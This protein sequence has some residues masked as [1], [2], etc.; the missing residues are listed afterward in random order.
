MGPLIFDKDTQI[1]VKKKDLII[2]E[3]SSIYIYVEIYRFKM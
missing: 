2:W 1:P 3:Y